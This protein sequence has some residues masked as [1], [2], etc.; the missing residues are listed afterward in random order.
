M[1]CL[2]GGKADH[3]G[4]E[5]FAHCTREIDQ[6]VGTGLDVSL[7]FGVPCLESQSLLMMQGLLHLG[8]KRQCGVVARYVYYSD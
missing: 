6:M 7:V 2:L 1:L 4:C 8:E 3:G 5:K